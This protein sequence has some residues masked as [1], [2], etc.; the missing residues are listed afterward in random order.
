MGLTQSIQHGAMPARDFTAERL[1]RVAAMERWHFWF[2]GRQA[3]VG[4]LIE[5]YVERS[6]RPVVDIGCGTGA[7]IEQLGRQ[8]YLALG[9]DRRP[10]GLTVA[11]RTTPGLWLV[12]AEALQLP[13]REGAAAAV[14]LLDVLEH[15]D[16]DRA[17]LAEVAR[18]LREDGVALITVPALP[19][20][21]SH[22]DEAAGHK[23]RY[24]KR[25]LVRRL[26]EAGFAVEKVRHY[27]F[28]L[29]PLVLAARWL[30]RKRPSVS[31]LEERPHQI[32]NTLLGW[33]NLLE[34]RLADVIAWPW[35]SSLVVVSRKRRDD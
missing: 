18:L 20:L 8:G 17:L 9:L 5:R 27:Q 31:D 15:V 3:L 28:F 12:Q 7:W 30:G 1:A 23:R 22:R 4:R 33:I 24:T 34:A 2:I 35:G 16:D 13:L 25:T 10:E 21:W 6:D 19:W 32:I 14:T 29:F 11:R 26:T